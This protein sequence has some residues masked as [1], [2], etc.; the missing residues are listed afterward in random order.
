MNRASALPTALIAALIAALFAALLTPAFAQAPARTSARFTGWFV[1]CAG[2]EVKL[3]PA[4]HSPADAATASIWSTAPDG[5]T[6]EWGTARQFYHREMP[7]PSGSDPLRERVGKYKS[8]PV[9]AGTTFV[10]GGDGDRSKAASAPYLAV[11]GE[12]GGQ[13]IDGTAF[14]CATPAI[15]AALRTRLAAGGPFAVTFRFE[16]PGASPMLVAEKVGPDPTP[17]VEVKPPK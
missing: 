16:A 1:P 17:P 12:S 5:I 13:L 9:A 15:C 3:C 2:P 11:S 4:V 10:F 8:I 14:A 7:A 6:F